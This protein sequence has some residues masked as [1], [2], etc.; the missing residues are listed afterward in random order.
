MSLGSEWEGLEEPTPRRTSLITSNQL[1]QLHFRPTVHCSSSLLLSLKLNRP[2]HR[3][4]FQ[5]CRT[6]GHPSFGPLSTWLGDMPGYSEVGH[7]DVA[8]VHVTLSHYNCQPPRA[9]F[10]LENMSWTGAFETRT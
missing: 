4:W 7:Q 10:P 5:L 8:A 6:S 2:A 1:K 9:C 3:K